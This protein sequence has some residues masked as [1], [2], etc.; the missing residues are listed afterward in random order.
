MKNLL[1]FISNFLL[2]FIFGFDI[3]DY[4]LLGGFNVINND[5]N[6]IFVMWFGFIVT[7]LSSVYFYYLYL[8]SKTIKHET[9]D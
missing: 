4:Y 6:R 9:I 7:V 8:N 5:I 3:M 2:S 1:G